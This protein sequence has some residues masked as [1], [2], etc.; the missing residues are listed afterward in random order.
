MPIGPDEM[1][2]HSV[3]ICF[4]VQGKFELMFSMDINKL[5]NEPLMTLKVIF[6]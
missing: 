3:Y 2:A 1:T 5:E 6:K 4:R